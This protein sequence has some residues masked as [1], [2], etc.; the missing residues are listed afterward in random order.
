MPSLISF[1]A[2]MKLLV[3]SSGIGIIPAQPPPLDPTQTLPV[4]L[5]SCIDARELESL[6]GLS[7]LAWSLMQVS[8]C[9]RLYDSAFQYRSQITQY[10]STY[11][12]AII[13]P[14]LGVDRA[15]DFRYRELYLENIEVWQ[16]ILRCQVWWTTA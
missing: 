12:G 10:L 13:G 4:V 2:G 5:V 6:S 7:G 16:L 1:V 3:D 14:A 8:V 15:T 11:T 9:D